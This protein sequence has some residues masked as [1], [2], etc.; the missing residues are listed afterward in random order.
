MSTPGRRTR[1]G[2]P[3]RAGVFPAA[4]P[5]DGDACDRIAARSL[6]HTVALFPHAAPSIC[7]AGRDLSHRLL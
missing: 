6:E 7:R 2:D 1:V 4:V 3:G 5:N